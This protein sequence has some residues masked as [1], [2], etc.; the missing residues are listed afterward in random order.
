MSN[1][2]MDPIQNKMSYS[3]TLSLKVG[4]GKDQI[5]LLEAD[6]KIVTS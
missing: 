1:S 6:A 5:I 3:V 2:I 4:G